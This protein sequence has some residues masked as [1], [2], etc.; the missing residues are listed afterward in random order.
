MRIRSQSAFIRSILIFKK[1]VMNEYKFEKKVQTHIIN[2]KERR[3]RERKREIEIRRHNSQ[4][5]W[6]M[7]FVHFH[8]RFV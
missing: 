8:L 4:C 6:V 5:E 3:K 7:H 1:N 2:E